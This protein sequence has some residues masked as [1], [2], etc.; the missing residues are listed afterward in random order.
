MIEIKFEGNNMENV[1]RQIQ[2]F[3]ERVEVKE[4]KKR[5]KHESGEKA[6]AGEDHGDLG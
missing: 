3:A 4:V 6:S 2:A 5:G 1:L